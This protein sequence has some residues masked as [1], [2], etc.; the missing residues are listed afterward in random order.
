MLQCVAVC[1]RVMQC[2]FERSTCTVLRCVASRCVA[3]C[4][5][6][7]RA[8]LIECRALLTEYRALFRDSI[9]PFIS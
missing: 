1:C 4:S 7:S 9:V 3:A 5:L 8:L 2:C 6:D